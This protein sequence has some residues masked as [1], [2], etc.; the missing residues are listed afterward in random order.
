MAGMSSR[1]AQDLCLKALL[2]EAVSHSDNFP[3]LAKLLRIVTVLLASTSSC[4]RGFSQM[5][6]I[7]HQFRSSLES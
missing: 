7:K 2:A 4:E 3:D 6:L 1:C 5:A